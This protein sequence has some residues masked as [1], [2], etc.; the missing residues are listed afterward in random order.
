MSSNQVLQPIVTKVDTALANHVTSFSA[1]LISTISPLVQI[2]L[3]LYF[4]WLGIAYIKG[5]TDDSLGEIAWHIFRVGV[6]VAIA[7]GVGT[8]QSLIATPLQSLPDDLASSL[9]SGSGGSGMVTLVDSILDKGI[10]LS[11]K[12]YSMIEFSPISDIAGAV[13]GAIGDVVGIG[14]GD[15]GAEAS[16]SASGTQIIAPIVCGTA[17]IIGTVF[18]LIVGCFWYLATKFL[19]ALLLGFGALFIVALVWENTRSYF[20]A[21]L[22]A[23]LALM[24]INLMVTACFTIFA[25]IF[26]SRLVTLES[27]AAVMQTAAEL[28]MGDALG[29]GFMGL[30][31]CAT[32]LMLPSIA[33]MLAQ[34]G[35]AFGGMMGAVGGAVA[36]SGAS[37]AGRA[38]GGAAVHAARG[39]NAGAAARA[40]RQQGAVGAAAK[41]F[42]EGGGMNGAK[43]AAA[44]YFRK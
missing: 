34:G 38:A 29:M 42:G 24:L 35:G 7:M 13:G 30:L 44:N 41:A 28:K 4:I 21:W 1:D 43:A 31:V 17:V 3:V 37:A 39:G 25:N 8:Y 18:C 12:Y 19:I 33:S 9:L 22:N 15:A 23:M 2:G 5:L 6:I 40:G 14:G 32:L 16:S 27:Q 36:A 20:G 10:N 26:E 11:V